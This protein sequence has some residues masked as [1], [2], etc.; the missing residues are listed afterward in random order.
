MSIRE[1]YVPSEELAAV[2]AK[3]AAMEQ[4][5]IGDLDLQWV[6]VLA[7]GWAS[8]LGG[9]M[10]EKEYLQSLYF[11]GLVEGSLVSRVARLA[12]F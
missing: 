8:P 10:R 5:E 4:L 2:R 11:G 1:L 7:E 12:C 3:S 9:F 6:Q